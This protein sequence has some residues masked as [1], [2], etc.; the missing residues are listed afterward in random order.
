MEKFDFKM[1]VLGPDK[2]SQRG[3]GEQWPPN[4]IDLAQTGVMASGFEPSVFVHAL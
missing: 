4:S 3:V 2:G 1:T